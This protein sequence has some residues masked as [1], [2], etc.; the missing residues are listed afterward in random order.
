MTLKKDAPYINSLYV[1]FHLRGQGIGSA[2]LGEAKRLSNYL[3]LH[4]YQKDR[5]AVC[6]YIRQHFVVRGVE[7]K[8]EEG[9]GQFKYYMRW[10]RHPKA[11]TH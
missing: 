9:T 1:D 11:D 3:D 7:D 5:D 2:L 6:F 4:V 10:E 8:P